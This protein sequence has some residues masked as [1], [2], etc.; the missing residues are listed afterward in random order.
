MFA[1]LPSGIREADRYRCCSGK[2]MV[3]SRLHQIRETPQ[4]PRSWDTLVPR[5]SR[6]RNAAAPVRNR[7]R[8]AEDCT[9]IRVGAK[10]SCVERSP[11]VVLAGCEVHEVHACPCR[12]TGARRRVLSRSCRARATD[13]IAR[14]GAETE[15]NGRQND[16]VREEPRKVG[17]AARVKRVTSEH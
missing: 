1:A 6:P 14:A 12:P 11:A 13:R 4:N 2:G 15:K 9:T 17:W 10:A 16:R 5:L 8:P 3:D 7:R